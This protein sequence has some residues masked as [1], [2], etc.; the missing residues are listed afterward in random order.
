MIVDFKIECNP[1]DD[2]YWVF[3]GGVDPVGK[4]FE[5]EGEWEG[6]P[7]NMHYGFAQNFKTPVFFES[8]Y[9][10]VNEAFQSVIMKPM[11]D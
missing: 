1:E 11:T 6:V 9:S 3:D 2:I 7:S 5:L 8:W 4:I 10:A